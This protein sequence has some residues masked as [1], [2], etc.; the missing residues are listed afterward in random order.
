[1]QQAAGAGGVVGLVYFGVQRLSQCGQQGGP[2]GLRGGAAVFTKDLR[3]DGGEAA[4]EG[5]GETLHL[6]DGQGFGGGEEALAFLGDKGEGAEA[7]ASLAGEGG[8]KRVDGG[9]EGGEDFVADAFDQQGAFFPRGDGRAD[10]VF[11]DHG[12]HG[13]GQVGDGQ[14]EGG[15]GGEAVGVGPALQG[16]EG[17][18]AAEAGDEAVA[19]GFGGVVQGPDLDRLVE[20]VG[21]DGEGEFVECRWVKRGAVAQEGVFADFGEGDVGEVHDA[22]FRLRHGSRGWLL[23]R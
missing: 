3:D 22:A 23:R 13:V 12:G 15:D 7:V 11:G 10:F 17:G 16:A 8:V 18:E 2:L 5:G 21:E 20:A 1:M 4:A 6:L 19:V 14:H 9:V